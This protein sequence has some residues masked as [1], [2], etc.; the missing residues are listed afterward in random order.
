MP[1]YATTRIAPKWRGATQNENPIISTSDKQDQSM[2]PRH[3]A[4]RTWESQ[5]LEAVAWQVMRIW[6][7]SRLDDEAVETARTARR[8]TR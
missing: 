1:H 5:A 8:N 4:E 2:K 3:F 6:V 7:E